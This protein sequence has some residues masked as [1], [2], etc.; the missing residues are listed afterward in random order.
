MKYSPESYSPVRILIRS[1]FILL[2]VILEQSLSPYP[3]FSLNLVIPNTRHTIFFRPPLE[4]IKRPILTAPLFLIL[5][6]HKLTDS[7]SYNYPSLHSII[8]TCQMMLK[9]RCVFFKQ[10][11]PHALLGHAKGI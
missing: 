11:N 4:T 2:P 9:S 3:P 1:N 6:N 10:E 7:P 5:P 8:S